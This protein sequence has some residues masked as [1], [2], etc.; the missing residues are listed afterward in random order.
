[1]LTRAKTSAQSDFTCYPCVKKLLSIAFL[2]YLPFA[3]TVF[4]VDGMGIVKFT[5]HKVAYLKKIT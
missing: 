3:L 1:M 2:A 5:L 4:C